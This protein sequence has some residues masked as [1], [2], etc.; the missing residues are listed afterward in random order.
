MVFILK[1]LI[2][3]WTEGI[4]S[5]W[6]TTAVFSK[7]WW[8]WLAIPLLAK[9]LFKTWKRDTAPPKKGFNIKEWLNRHLFNLFSRLIGFAIRFL[10]IIFGL[11]LQIVWWISAILLFPL[12][13]LSPLALVALILLIPNVIQN[14]SSPTASVEKVP[15]KLLQSPAPTDW[16]ILPTDLL[17]K[18]LPLFIIILV[19]IIL[20]TLE[21]KTIQARYF[22][23]FLEPDPDNPGNQLW[24]QTVCL[25]LMQDSGL[26]RD[27]W[28]KKGMKEILRKSGLN[29]KEFEKLVSWEIARQKEYYQKRCWWLSQS[30]FS[31]SPLTESWAFGWTFILDRF[32]RKLIHEVSPLPFL[33][34]LH[35]ASS[36]LLVNSLKE[37]E[38]SNIVI[39]GETGSGR[40]RLVHE[41]AKSIADRN[42]PP[43]LAGKRLIKFR[44]DDLLAMSSQEDEKI[45]LLK[46]AFNETV[47]SGNVILFIPSL[48]SYLQPKT[49]EDQIG[50]ADISSV[51]VEFLESTDLHMVTLATPLEL[52]NILQKKQNLAK[53]FKTI[54]L[55]EPKD[56]DSLTALRREAQLIE[57]RTPVLLTYPALKKTLE[58][59]KRYSQE[60]AM[61]GR[62]IELLEELAVYWNNEN[63]EYQIIKEEEVEKFV[64]TK[65][66]VSVGKLKGKEKSKLLKLE[67]EM[68]K[69]IVGQRPGIKAVSSALRRR[70]L[71]LSNPER[72]AGTFLFIGPTGVGK[73]HTAEVLAKIYFK[74]EAKIARMDMSEYQDESAIEKLLGDSTGKIEGQFHKILTENPF[75]L[76]LLDELEKASRNVHQLLLQIMEEGMAKTGTGSKLNFRETLIIA[77]SNAQAEYVRKLFNEGGE[78]P[79]IKR[80]SVEKIQ[81]EGIFS[82]ELLNRFDD[83]MAFHP[84]APEQIFQVTGLILKQLK[85][86]LEKQEIL[87]SYTDAFQQKLAEIGFHPTF[88]ARQI[89]RVVQTN[90]EDSIAKDLLEEKI[91]K[92]K[93][94]EL[95]ISYLENISKS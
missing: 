85:D 30:L 67:E 8:H 80:A 19:I 17:I 7:F 27:N 75:N 61:P 95:P 55:E 14:I 63:R 34:S 6:K 94:F 43:E 29:Q 37:Q 45:N 25:H 83:I 81:K 31:K 87:I 84:L 39:V 89:R 78:Y 3:R 72:P 74:G 46:R 16:N 44:L 41:L 13:L 24:F 66:G 57:S 40:T 73:T 69:Y 11:L 53:Y 48:Y 4:T 21:I 50:G 28:G 33:H 51:L 47:S 20:V 54:K 2:W 26:V 64:S 77:T 22:K 79:E 93:Q 65:L 36:E 42:I 82:P 1:Y 38:G 71:D 49:D 18:L 56:E 90:I 60:P 32:S 23:K 91:E 68:G 62:A 12:W 35:P 88:G 59:A 86:R 9:T 70:R 10:T 15:G 58:S 76:I 52:N 92:G 5:Y